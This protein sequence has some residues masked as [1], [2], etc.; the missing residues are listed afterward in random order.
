MT[1]LAALAAL[2]ALGVFATPA[3][4]QTAVTLESGF[5]PDPVVV[6]GRTGGERRL[7]EMAP[8][9]RG[10]VGAEPSH[11][12]DLGS[13]FG[14]L[15]LFVR[16]S[17]HVTL[18]MR[19][20]D[21]GWRCVTARD[22]H[23]ALLEGRFVAGAHQVWIASPEA[24]QELDYELS[25]TEFRSV[26]PGSGVRRIGAGDVGLD[27]DAEEGRHRDR[28]L[29]R[30]FLPD[31]R[32][33][34]GSAGGVIDVR[35]LGA[36]CQGFVNSTPSHVLT[37]RD[38]F[39]YLRVQLGEVSGEATIILRTPGGRYLCSAPSDTNAHVDQDAWVRGRYLIWIGS[40]TREAQPEYR[41]CYTEI[42]RGEG[43]VQCRS[44]DAEHATDRSA[45]EGEETP[46]A[47]NE[48][49]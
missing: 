16:A 11:T 6:M 10:F 40:R 19:A 47:A 35:L 5:T 38:D 36:E 17:Q 41:I 48:E 20:P 4:A 13:R 42:R 30:G 45:E 18:A 23:A 2:A 25:I 9:C 46:P 3:H 33:D 44:E 14:F 29:R 49:P 31:P 12:L 43:R 1:R 37:L 39:D 15:R 34:G 22:N 8:T 24:S 32:Q 27:V 21:G 26:G 7:G 28:R